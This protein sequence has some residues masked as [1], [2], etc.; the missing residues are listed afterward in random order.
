[1]S[2]RVRYIAVRGVLDTLALAFAVAGMADLTPAA[3]Q[4]QVPS[5]QQ[6]P[7]LAPPPSSRM[8]PLPPAIIDDTLTI[9]GDDISGH[10]TESRMTVSVRVTGRG[11]YRFLVD[12]GA[13][14][15]V[16]G[17]NIAR[18]LQL[19]PGRPATLHGMTASSR[20]DRVIIDSLE[21]GEST[22]H[23]LQLPVLHERDLGG[24]GI[25]GIDALVN[26]RLMLDFERGVIKVE[27]ATRPPP[28]L[29]DEIVVTA[30]RKRGQLII[31][32]ARANGKP[33]NAVIDTGTEVTIGNLALRNLLIRSYRKPFTRGRIVGVTG[34]PLDLEMARIAELRLGPVILRNVLIAFADVPPFAVFGLRDEPALMLGTDLMETFR[35]VSLD[36]RARKVRFQLKRCRTTG[37]TI[38]TDPGNLSRLSVASDGS[39]ACAR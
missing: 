23:H 34:V 22:L 18:A 11:P 30:R 31:T 26:Q 29:D 33:V 4:A 32:Q 24:Q 25:L 8:P 27:D 28:R 5:R 10:K 35:R 19:P 15:S 6:E 9:G 3:A 36:F 20:V 2:R 16:I 37:I 13:D 17:A 21:L 14:T 7:R 12:S 39:A 1:M 38:D